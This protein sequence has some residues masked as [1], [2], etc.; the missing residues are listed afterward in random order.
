MKKL[1]LLLAVCFFAVGA[2]AHWAETDTTNL[3]RSISVKVF[4]NPATDNITL[5]S[6]DHT[7][8]A[9]RITNIAGVQVHYTKLIRPVK[10]NKISIKN[11]TNGIYLIKVILSTGESVT[12]KLVVSG[13]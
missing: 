13:K 2:T 4:P 1:L 8:H 10:V 3:P 9:L 11:L 7:I 6:A 12:R 5:E